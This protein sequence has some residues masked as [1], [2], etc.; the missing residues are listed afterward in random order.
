MANLFDL[1]TT[2][3]IIWSEIMNIAFNQAGQASNIEQ[4]SL[5]SEKIPD[6]ELITVFNEKLCDGKLLAKMLI[7]SIS[8]KDCLDRAEQEY[9]QL[10]KNNKIIQCASA[11]LLAPFP[12]Q[13]LYR[14]IGF[15]I[16]ADRSIQKVI[17][18]I[19]M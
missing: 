12:H 18:L 6:S 10:G 3:E 15:L 19:E 13:R 4:S 16:D 7:N 9:I 2:N 14:R 5:P 11:S 1:L 8:N 17:A